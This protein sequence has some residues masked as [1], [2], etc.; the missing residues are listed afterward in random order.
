M[1]MKT[2][3]TPE[4]SERQAEQLKKAVERMRQDADEKQRAPSRQTIS[5]RAKR[6]QKKPKG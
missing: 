4:D 1:L 2:H 3:S 5:P 6:S